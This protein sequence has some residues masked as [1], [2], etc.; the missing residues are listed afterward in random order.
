MSETK[1]KPVRCEPK[2]YF[3]AWDSRGNEHVILNVIDVKGM[4]FNTETLGYGGF[5]EWCDRMNKTHKQAR[6]PTCSLW[7]IWLPRKGKDH[8]KAP[9]HGEIGCGCLN[10]ISER[11]HR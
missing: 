6:C 5:F 8:G 3:V 1:K 4:R 11:S 7:S 2:S 9:I 10:C